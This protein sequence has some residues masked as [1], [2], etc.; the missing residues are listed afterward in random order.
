VSDDVA[1]EDS[2]HSRGRDNDRHE[3]GIGGRPVFAR[4]M[5]SSLFRAAGRDCVAGQ[6][7]AFLGPAAPVADGV[8]LATTTNNE[9]VH[10][11]RKRRTAGWPK[12]CM[13]DEDAAASP[14]PC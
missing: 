10:D 9:A 3:F 8:A 12:A 2:Q 5:R 1:L 7:L 11:S 14:R 4:R 13:M 6:R